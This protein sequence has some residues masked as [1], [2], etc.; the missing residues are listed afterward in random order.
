[1]CGHSASKA[2]N[3]DFLKVIRTNTIHD[4]PNFPY[5]PLFKVK[6]AECTSRRQFQLLF[7][8]HFMTAG[9]PTTEV[10]EEGSGSSEVT[11]TGLEFSGFKAGNGPASLPASSSVAAY[12]LH[13]PTASARDNRVKGQGRGDQSRSRKSKI[14]QENQNMRKN[15]RCVLI[16]L[17]SQT[18]TREDL[19][20]YCR[21]IVHRNYHKVFHIQI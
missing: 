4:Y 19:T 13:Q 8:Q 10:L 1:M 18:Q 6:A 20:N 11:A 7:C 15:Y 2:P 3:E 12:L 5:R 21:L 14:K 9:A 17:Q 16:K